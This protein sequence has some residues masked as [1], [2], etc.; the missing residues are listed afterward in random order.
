VPTINRPIIALDFKD[1]AT[2]RAFLQLFGQDSHLFVKIGM[3][4]FY[5]AGPDIV[6][7]ITAAGHDVF[8]DLKLHDIPHTVEMG[9]R[10]IA[11]LG[12]TMTTTHISGGSEMLKAA[13]A[14]LDAGAT[15]KTPL[16]L[17]IT[18]LTST[19]ETMMNRE[20]HIPG[21]LADD[22]L[23]R[24]RIADASGCDG[25]VCSAMEASSILEATG[26]DFL[27]ITPGIRPT[28]NATDD[29]VRVVTPAQA[30][31]LNS[32]GIVVGRPITQAADPVNA[33]AAILN[34]WNLKG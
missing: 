33:Y 31:T 12:A 5:S 2:T 22:V 18:Q 27:R 26:A 6:R 16:L 19:S 13:R 30:R 9:M 21:A 4:L 32:S 20:Q 1:A 25:V 24:A 7:E 28:N 17:G 14:G 15:T 29:Q 23:H 10:S 11:R 34:A 3:E 8:L